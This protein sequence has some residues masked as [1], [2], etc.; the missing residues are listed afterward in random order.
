ML[1]LTSG[2]LSQIH[3]GRQ[4]DSYLNRQPE[5]HHCTDDKREA[6]GRRYVMGYRTQKCHKWMGP[7]CGRRKCN[8]LLMSTESFYLRWT[9]NLCVLQ[10]HGRLDAANTPCGCPLEL[11]P[12]RNKFTTANCEIIKFCLLLGC[13]CFTVWCL[14]KYLWNVKTQT[15]ILVQVVLI[16]FTNFNNVLGSIQKTEFYILFLREMGTFHV[17]TLGVD[18]V[19]FPS[20]R[21]KDS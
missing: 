17:M 5:S 19:S 12:R 18:S 10:P 16:S 3:R 7:G 15:P 4:S 14:W 13:M 8:A 20:N 1:W 9:V 6:C 11:I 2:V 21:R